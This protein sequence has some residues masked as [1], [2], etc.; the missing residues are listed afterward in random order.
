MFSPK[1]SDLSKCLK[2]WQNITYFTLSD[3]VHKTIAG[4]YTNR[5]IGI[6]LPYTGIQKYNHGVQVEDSKCLLILLHSD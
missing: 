4:K 5:E 6:T 3:K 2:N 1:V